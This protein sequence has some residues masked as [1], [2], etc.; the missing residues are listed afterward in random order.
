VILC[1]LTGGRTD[2]CAIASWRINDA[3]CIVC[4]GRI[5]WFESTKM[6]L[7]LDSILNV[8][9]V[10]NWQLF[11]G[12]REGREETQ[13]FLPF[14]SQEK[15]FRTDRARSPNGTAWRLRVRH[16]DHYTKLSGCNKGLGDAYSRESQIVLFSPARWQ[17]DWPRSLDNTFETDSTNTHWEKIT[18][19]LFM[20][21]TYLAK[22]SC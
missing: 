11:V 18:C 4:Y 7:S 15:N 17:R 20:P 8:M 19:Y 12:K 2:H 10:T 3:G 22:F 6:I 14:F 5:A 9:L 1:K 13:F 16:F 21:S